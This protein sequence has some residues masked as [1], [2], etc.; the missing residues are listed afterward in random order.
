[1]D[2]KTITIS[3]IRIRWLAYALALFLLPIFALAIKDKEWVLL[4]YF[5]VLFG[6]PLSFLYIYCGTVT[7]SKKTFQFNFLFGSFTINWADITNYSVGGGNLKLRGNNISIT[8]PG[9][10]FWHGLQKNEAIELFNHQICKNNVNKSWGVVA[11]IPTY[12][13]TK[14]A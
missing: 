12:Y 9:F 3:T 2:D 7:L 6:I 10:E 14:N 4:M 8:T 5:S 11:L 1:M 13:G